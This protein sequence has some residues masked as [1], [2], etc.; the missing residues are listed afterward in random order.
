MSDKTQGSSL[1]VDLVTGLRGLSGT[2]ERILYRAFLAVHTHINLCITDEYFKL[3]SSL[4]RR[5][6]LSDFIDF[7][8]SRDE[9]QAIG[10]AMMFLYQL[11]VE[12]T[13]HLSYGDQ[14]PDNATEIGK[15]DKSKPCS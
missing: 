12:I 11:D 6:V 9:V 1:T 3:Y 4:K 8:M 13:V 14:A 2:N 7:L 15:D 10:I 5:F